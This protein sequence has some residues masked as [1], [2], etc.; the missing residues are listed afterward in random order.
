MMNRSP[1]VMTYFHP[2][3][4]DP[5]QPVI[6]E[7]SFFRKF[8]SYVGL[9]SAFE[10]LELLIS[11]FEFLDIAGADSQIDWNLAKRIKL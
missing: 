2:R 5:D 7:L 4:F 11:D 1:Y 9:S 3:D 10:K 8:K 6:Q